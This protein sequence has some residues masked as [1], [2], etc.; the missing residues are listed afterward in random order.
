VTER[1]HILVG[2][3]VLVGL[4]LL[5]VLIV[6]FEGVGH[7]IRGGYTVRAH[8]PNARGITVGKRVHLDGIEI[9]DV[10]E[11][12]TSQPAR[13]GVWIHMRINP[14]VRIPRTARLTAQSTMT[15]DQYLD[16]QTTDQTDACLA[17]D[18]SAAVEGFVK[19]PSLVPEDIMIVF[20]DAM[21]KFEKLDIILANVSELTAPRTLADVEA[22]QCRNLWTSLAQFEA[23]AKAVQDELQGPDSRFAGLLAQAGKVAEELRTVVAR[24]RTTLDGVDK[25]FASLDTTAKTV[26]DTGK[27]A[28]ALLAK[29]DA[30]MAKLAKDAEKADTLLV[31]L[32]AAVTDVRQGKGTAGKLLTD[33]EL[34]RALVTL[35]ENL[36]HMTDNADRLLTLWR[37]EGVLAKEGK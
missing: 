37:K 9:G 3:F 16:F 33:D 10:T 28:G 34:Y 1:T 2:L 35:T 22:G 17:T 20:R 25:A 18:G 13:A 4:I 7:L 30:L 19:A 21:E 36:Q 8:L 5:G 23:T 27:K 26:N 29:S 15:G 14:D 32:N 24:A 11:I 12:T 31:N 6:W